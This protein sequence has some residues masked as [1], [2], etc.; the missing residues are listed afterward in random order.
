M[1]EY[2]RTYNQPGAIST[3]LA[4]YRAFPQDIE[5]NSEFVKTKLTMPV[6][7]IGGE[8]TLGDWAYKVMSIAAEFVRGVLVKDCG[9]WI[10]E[11]RPDELLN[12]LITFFEE[13]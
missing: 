11:E 7:T 10:S 13:V 6:L 12:Y 9:H 3:W 8:E 2:V 4:H 5:D 1:D